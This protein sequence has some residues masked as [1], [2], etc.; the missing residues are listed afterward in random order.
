MKDS[1]EY[2]GYTIPNKR[3]P[4]GSPLSAWDVALD[5]D[6]NVVLECYMLPLD[7]IEI[8]RVAD[9][10]AHITKQAFLVKVLGQDVS[11]T[12]VELPTLDASL[13]DDEVA[14]VKL[15]RAK[16]AKPSEKG[17]RKE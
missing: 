3:A 6:D 4:L 13:V 16:L 14:L 11:F 12:K 1:Y 15:Y 8:E 5:D 7:F 2:R 10:R 17:L 9:I